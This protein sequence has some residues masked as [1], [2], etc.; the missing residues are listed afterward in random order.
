MGYDPYLTGNRAE[1]LRVRLESGHP[2]SYQTKSEGF[3]VIFGEVDDPRLQIKPVEGIQMYQHPLFGQIRAVFNNER[4]YFVANDIAKILGYKDVNDAVV[5]HCPH[6][7]K[8][9][10]GVVTGVKNDGTNATQE[11]EMNII[12]EPDVYRLVFGSKLESAIRFQDWIFNDVIPMVVNTGKY[13]LDSFF[14]NPQTGRYDLN[15][16]AHMRAVLY[17]SDIVNMYNLNKKKLIEDLYAKRLIKNDDVPLSKIKWTKKALEL[18]VGYY[19]EYDFEGLPLACVGNL[20]TH[21][22]YSLQNRVVTLVYQDDKD[23]FVPKA[24]YWGSKPRF[25]DGKYLDKKPWRDEYYD[26]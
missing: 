17:I 1:M 21:L 24:L 22:G 13:T 14:H 11:V 2:L 19:S 10:V 12:P 18:E 15:G 16:Y 7:E 6:K 23:F 25:E 4:P 9:L 8:F 3:Q 5:N 26:D 20:F